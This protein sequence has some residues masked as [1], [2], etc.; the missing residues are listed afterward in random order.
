MARLCAHLRY[1]YKEIADA[2]W[3]RVENRSEQRECLLGARMVLE[4]REAQVSVG[5]LE[6][7]ADELDRGIRSQRWQH[8]PQQGPA[9]H[10]VSGV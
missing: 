4:V 6:Q 9:R 7:F 2:V 8:I 5:C 10:V 3:V 1:S